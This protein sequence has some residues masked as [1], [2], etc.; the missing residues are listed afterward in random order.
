M[1]IVDGARGEVVI[2]PSDDVLRSYRERAITEQRRT[3]QLLVNRDQPAVTLDGVPITLGANVE[4][5]LGVTA[6]TAAGADGIGLF[7]TELLYLDRPDL[8]DEEEQYRDAVLVLETVGGRC[9]TFRTLDLGGDKLP[10]AIKMPA[11]HN[12]ALGVRSLRFSLEQ[13]DIFRT[14]VRALYRA[15]AH[16]PMRIMLPLVTSSQELRQVLAI[17]A[18]VCESLVTEGIA[19]D[20]GLPIGIMIETP[21]AAL[22]ADLLAKQAGF[23]SLGTNDLIQY[24]CAADRDNP[25]VAHLRDPLQPAILRLVKHTV[26]AAA[27]ARIPISICG[28]MAGDPSLTW[29]LLGFGLR[30]LSMEAQSIPAVKDVIRRSSMEEAETLAKKVLSSPD[31]RQTAHLILAAMGSTFAEELERLRAST[32]G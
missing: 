12:P 4:S 24:A 10:L 18:R 2:D 5:P 8:P 21:S 7:R 17:C 13:P 11:C 25:D 29:L 31:E 32:E 19:H 14:Q 16:G 9:V 30:D 26:D 28:D 27:R 23:F 22:T 3:E 1:V 20:A 6:A 15:S